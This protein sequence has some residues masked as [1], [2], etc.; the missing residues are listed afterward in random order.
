MIANK[1]KV[2][3]Q[4]LIVSFV[5]ISFPSHCKSKSSD[6]L[7]YVIKP[8]YSF[9]E[10]SNLFNNNAEMYKFGA[11]CDIVDEDSAAYHYYHEPSLFSGFNFACGFKKYPGKEAPPIPFIELDLFKQLITPNKQGFTWELRSGI[12]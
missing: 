12:F 8:Y 9:F 1:Q 11:G 4:F 3:V 5:S 2:L 6:S 10:H 7:S